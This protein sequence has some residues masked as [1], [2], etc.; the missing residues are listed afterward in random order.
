VHILGV[1]K[2]GTTDLYKRLARHPDFVESSNKGPHFW[3]ESPLPPAA[4]S[5]FSG[6]LS[7]FNALAARVAAAPSA[8]AGLVTA[9]A[10]SNTLTAAGVWR[11]GH[12]PVGDVTIGELL[13]EA[14]P[15]T[16]CIAMLREPGERLFSAFHYYKRMYGGGGP[17]PSAADFHTHVTESI[18]AWNACVA[19]HAGDKGAHA[20]RLHPCLHAC[21]PC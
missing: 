7:L 20:T 9:D 6:Y 15:Y 13:F 12:A 10:S 18:G 17:P 11:R 2:C 4:L 8:S 3:D 14:A 5:D 1:S 19:Q 21:I 16:R